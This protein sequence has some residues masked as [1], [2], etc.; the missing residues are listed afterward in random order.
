MSKEAR[1]NPEAYLQKARQELAAWEVSKRSRFA[2]FSDMLL[3]PAANLTAK[4]IPQSVQLAV[5]KVIEKTL[6]L[7]AQAGEFSVGEDA[8]VKKRAKLLGRKRALGQRLKVCDAM[9][10]GF[11]TNHCGYAAAEGAA[12]GVIGAAGFVADIPLLLSIAIRVIR[13]I[14]L[15]YGYRPMAPH[16]TDYMLHILRIGSSG[17]SAEKTASMLALRQLDRIIR[18]GDAQP[19]DGVVRVTHLI[20][21]QEYAKS[22][23][24]DLVKRKALQFVPLAGAVTAASFNAAYVN[25]VGRAAYM[26]YRR[27]FLDDHEHGQEAAN[28]GYLT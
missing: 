7:T 11:W 5:S 24:M 2:Q 6:R 27:R 18:Q 23:G 28:S 17:E 25:D 19:D 15:C 8:I 22:L 14:G 3:K 21:L 4:A 20:T 26:C 1:P 13:T 9:S 10:R 16:E 12:T